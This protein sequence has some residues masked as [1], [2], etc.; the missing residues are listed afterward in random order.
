[1]Q[2]GELR[3]GVGRLHQR[4]A[5]E[6]RVRAGELG[7]G[8]LGAA[9][10]AALGDDDA[11]LRRSRD[12]LELPRAVDLERREVAGVD[13]DRV[14]SERDGARELRRRRA[15][16][17]R[18]RA[19][20]RAAQAIRRAA[21][22]SSR[23]RS[24]SRIASAPASVAVRRSS[25]VE[26]NPFARSGR[27]VAARAAR[28]SSQLP[29]KR[30]ASTRIE[31]AAA[32]GPLVGGGDGRG[33]GVRPQVAGRRRAPLDL[34]DRR[35]PRR[36]RARRGSVPSGGPPRRGVG[37]PRRENA[38]SSSSRR[39]AAPESTASAASPMP[40]RRSRACP[41]AAIAPAALRTTASRRGPGRAG[42]DVADRSGRCPRGSRPRA[43][44][45]RSGRC[46]GRAGRSRRCRTE[47]LD[48]LADEVRA[49]GGELVDAVG[50][51]DDEGALGAE[52]GEDGGDRRHELG[53]VDA[54]DLGPRAGGVRQRPE[55]V[56]DRAHRE[57]AP[58]R[59]RIAHRRMV[60]GR[61]E[62]AEA[63]LVD[64]ALDPL[65]GQLEVEP[66]R[67]EDVRRARGRGDRAVAVL[68]DPGA[69]GRGDE[70]GRGRDVERAGAVAA[71]ARGVDEV[72]PL[73]DARRARARASPRRSPRSRPA[74]RLLIRIAIRKAPICAAVASPRMI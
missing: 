43:R 49:G 16:R 61:E 35:E 11:I 52:L 74:S 28:R 8:A 3:G 7:R 72:L 53:R 38:T 73:R 58:D 10:D 34:G 26:K 46:R 66:E 13:P 47:P 15:P 40:S 23:S 42:E 6:D 2:L 17:R 63:E 44:R 71:R 69:G 27:L 9:R 31:T 51:V 24:R 32:P 59:R 41:A 30:S 45:A 5:D 50:A 22:S 48:D 65:G 19:R 4:R 57:L 21:V 12:E 1:M 67:L 55:H 70:R 36:R 20:A 68:R 29:P 56:E 37:L 39:P 25:S 33:I 64:R 62:E 14:G 18:R 54:D 60:R